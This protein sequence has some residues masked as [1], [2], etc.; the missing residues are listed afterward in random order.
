MKAWTTYYMQEP[1]AATRLGL[2]EK[3]EAGGFRPI[4][5]DSGKHS[6]HG[7]AYFDGEPI[8]ASA[9]IGKILVDP[10]IAIGVRFEEIHVPGSVFRREVDK[11]IKDLGKEL[12]DDEKRALEDDV[13][14]LLRKRA[15]PEV[16]SVQ[17]LVNESG[18]RYWI[19]QCSASVRETVED[20]LRDL[21]V[22]G[23]VQSPFS[24]AVVDDGGQISMD[25]DAA[26]EVI[27]LFPAT[28]TE[29]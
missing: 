8:S 20:L 1:I 15:L 22:I 14:T 25:S 5:I 7:W 11:R 13:R 24:A 21:G 9:D 2:V 23:V 12:S 26:Q 3:L 10:V 16:S 27:D 6:S 18:R 17:V 4:D 28:F 29:V 19:G